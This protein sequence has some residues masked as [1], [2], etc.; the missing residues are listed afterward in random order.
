MTLYRLK[1]T[2]YVEAESESA[3]RQCYIDGD[4]DET[5]LTSIKAVG[6]LRKE[7]E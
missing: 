1:I 6:E 3:A 7:D 4:W 2:A 5:T